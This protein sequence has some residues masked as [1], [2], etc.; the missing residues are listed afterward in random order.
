[1]DAGEI[2][3]QGVPQRAQEPAP[4]GIPELRRPVAENLSMAV[5]DAD[6]RPP[7]EP[8][9][10]TPENPHLQY[11]ATVGAAAGV[12]MCLATGCEWGRDRQ[13]Q[14]NPSPPVAEY[15]R[16]A[17]LSTDHDESGTSA[18]GARSRMMER[19]MRSF[20]AAA[21]CLLLPVLSCREEG[22]SGPSFSRRDSAGVVI[23]ENLSP[24]W[25]EREL[26]QVPAVTTFDLSG[27]TDPELWLPTDAR[28]L[29]DGRLALFNP[30][31]CEIRF[32]DSEGGFESASGGCG[33]GPG[34]Y[35][36]G[37]ASLFPWRGDSLLVFDY[38]QRRAT[39]VDGSGVLGRTER[40]PNHADIPRSY[41]GGVL[42]DGTVVLY[43]ERDPV[44]EFGPGVAQGELSVGILRSFQ[45]SVQVVGIF[46]GREFEYWVGPDRRGRRRLAF[47]YTTEFV[48]GPDRLY[49]GF[50]DRYEI[51]VFR[52]DGTLER[53]IRREHS[54]MQVTQRD[55]D[56]I[57]EDLLATTEDPE[58]KR[59][60]RQGLR[61][62][63]FAPVM[64]AFGTTV[65]PGNPGGRPGMVADE[66]GNLWVRDYYRPGEYANRWSVF[67]AE[68]V[69]LGTVSLP[70]QFHPTQIGPDFLLGEM[71]GDLGVRHIRRF[72]LIKP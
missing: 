52:G 70:D 15:R 19:P 41:I 60:L 1:M 65:W 54:R 45:D 38:A 37:N 6:F 42:A 30:G 44:L 4:E 29:P 53:V 22:D 50:Q 32:Y 12:S 28:V 63:P 18:G 71:V 20:F 26:W 64:P 13:F 51:R 66:V 39:I 11:L 35:S 43:G 24:A 59:A 3:R 10:P 55:W 68:G 17:L 7:P 49:V 40:V 56:R 69:W 14:W 16:A 47:G 33:G 8:K 5:W 48:T 2:E 67:S 61:D 34:E 9:G 25:S 62:R 27:W 72:P 57:L 46:P 31:S 58:R 21:V 36:R 23:V